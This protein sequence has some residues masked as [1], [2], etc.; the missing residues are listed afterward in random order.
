MF[1]DLSIQFNHFV[2]ETWTSVYQLVRPI[3][4]RTIFTL[5]SAAWNVLKEILGTHL[6][7]FNILF[8][9]FLTN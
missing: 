5:E 9:F 8:L 1:E 7:Y 6:S 2:E 3:V 4:T